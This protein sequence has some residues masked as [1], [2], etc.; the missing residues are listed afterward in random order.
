MHPDALLRAART[1]RR[2]VHLG[3]HAM[4]A[5]A[6]ARSRMRL[7]TRARTR[8]YTHARARTEVRTRKHARS[9]ART[10]ALGADLQLSK[11]NA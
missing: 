8:T 2:D 11:C 3:T 7:H 6:R 10:H 1:L 9:H 4:F 5:H